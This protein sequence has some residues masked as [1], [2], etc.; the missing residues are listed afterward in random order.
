MI[1]IYARQSVDKKDSISIDGQ[2]SLCKRECEGEYTIFQDKGFSGKNTNRPAFQRMM[3]AVHNDEVEKIIVYRLDRI[4]RSITDFGSIWQTLNEHHAEFVSVNERFDTS[5]PMGRA[6]VYI[7][8]VFAQ[9]ERETIAERI[10]DNYYQRIKRGA[11]GGGEAP[12][13][14]DLKRID[15]DGKKATV[16]VP[17][18]KMDFVK[19]MFRRYAETGNSLSKIAEWMTSLEIPSSTRRKSGGWDNVTVARILHNPV[20]VKAD[21]DIYAYY[22]RRNAIIYQDIKEYT[23]EHGAQLYG[24]RPTHIAKF[25]TFD[26]HLLVLTHHLGVVDSNTFLE[27]QTKMSKNQQIKRTGS[28]KYSWLSGLYKC[29]YCGYSM[30]VIHTTS[31]SDT[32]EYFTLACSGRTNYHICDAKHKNNHVHQI[33]EYVSKQIEQQIE[34]IKAEPEPPKPAANNAEKIELVELDGQIERLIDSLSEANT[35][36]MQYINERLQKL[37]DRKQ[38]LLEK[39]D[40][41]QKTRPI[42]LPIYAFSSLGFEEKKHVAARLIKRV[43]ISNEEIKIEWK[44]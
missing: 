42:E 3:E 15:L 39:M 19:E 1:A 14:F 6:M 29:G 33:E 12:F 38:E 34:R 36:A 22:K 32:V 4:S 28:G 43:L 16:M 13:G 10:K 9:L 27:C 21:A 31:P 26:E 30:R 35:V 17:N 23:G 40:L 2:I 11:I 24:K 44:F 5:T 37:D 18:K 8:M 20:Y 41:K 25:S 7:I